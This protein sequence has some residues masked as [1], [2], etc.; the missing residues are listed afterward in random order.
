MVDSKQL[1]PQNFPNDVELGDPYKWN[2]LKS[3]VRH[4]RVCSVLNDVNL[5]E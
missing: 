3:E 4:N 2:I 1:R 5:V